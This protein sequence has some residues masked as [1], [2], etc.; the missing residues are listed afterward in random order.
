MVVRG[1]ACGGDVT[2]V[3]EASPPWSL[4]FQEHNGA[5]ISEDWSKDKE[6]E[7]FEDRETHRKNS[8]SRVLRLQVSELD[9]KLQIWSLTTQK[10]EEH[11]LEED[12]WLYREEQGFC[13]S[14]KQFRGGYFRDL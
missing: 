13:Q 2:G 10:G 7:T 1:A 4:S 5:R 14:L 3:E 8:S 9:Q 11:K 12:W 6:D